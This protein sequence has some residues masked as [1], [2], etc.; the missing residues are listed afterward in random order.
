MKRILAIFLTALCLVAPIFAQAQL[1]TSTTNEDLRIVSLAPNVTEII[2]ALGAGDELVGRTDYCNYPEQVLDIPSVGMMWQPNFELIV[3]LEPSVVI[4]SS[5]MDPEFIAKLNDSGIKAVQILK[6]ESLDGTFELI[7]EV[8]DAIGRTSEAKE[9][10]AGMKDRINAVTEVTSKIPEDQKK[11]AVYIISWGDWGDYA[12][13][14]DTYLEGVFE[15]AGAVNAAKDASNWSIS[16][17]LLISQDPDVVI[18]PR[19]SYSDSQ[20]DILAFTTTEPYSKLG[21]SVNSHVYAINGDA[22]ERQGV[23][24]ADT[25]EEIAKLLYP[26]LF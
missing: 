15:A 25:I 14:G 12:A 19:Y 1:E 8:G 3:S 7:Q 26:E 10:V 4:A 24:T 22:A 18:L 20:S 9:L 2:Y 17:E 13:T 11:S 6:E 23:R 21:A 16:K 5:I